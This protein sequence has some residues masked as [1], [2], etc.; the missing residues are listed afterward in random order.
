VTELI[1]RCR[2][3]ARRYEPRSPERTL[4]MAA[5][6]E[7]EKAQMRVPEEGVLDLT[8]VIAATSV[9]QFADALGIKLLPWQR[10]ILEARARTHVE[11]RA[12]VPPTAA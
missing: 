3:W 8:A 11:A 6:E 9:D 4:F 12:G 1:E 2:A 10:K 5:A 7:L